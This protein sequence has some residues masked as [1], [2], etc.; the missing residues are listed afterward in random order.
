MEGL[1]ASACYAPSRG[2]CAPAMDVDSV[3]LLLQ[4]LGARLTVSGVGL[5]SRDRHCLSSL[6]QLL[7]LGTNHGCEDILVHRH[8]EDVSIQFLRWR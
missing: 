4:V 7:N 8:P 1:R 5:S 2:L 3:F 6:E